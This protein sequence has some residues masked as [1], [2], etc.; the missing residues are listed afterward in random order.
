MSIEGIDISMW[1]G[2]FPWNEAVSQGIGWC[3]AKASEGIG[4]TDPQWQN[5]QRALLAPG[6]IV[7]GS[8]HFL[9]PDLGNDPAG[10]ADWYLSRHDLKCF[11]PATPWIFAL[12]A[13]SNGGSAGGCYAFLDHV[14][15]R[16]GYSCWFYSYSNWIDTRGVQAFNRPLWIAWPN[17]GPAPSHGWPTITAV[18]YGIRST[19]SVGGVD[20]DRFE[21]DQAALLKL[22]GASGGA[23]PV[24]SPPGWDG[25]YPMPD[26]PPAGTTVDVSYSGIIMAGA[27][28]F[29]SPDGADMGA[30]PT[31]VRITIDRAGF[32]GVNWFDRV[33]GPGSPDNWWWLLDSMVDSSDAAHPP[34]VGLT[35][36]M[37]WNEAHKPAPAPA[38]VPPPPTPPPPAPN[39]DEARKQLQIAAD[40]I[41]AAQTAL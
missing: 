2:V 10:E 38:P 26:S 31:G 34:P 22:A 28:W 17:P 21:G 37:A 15:A 16:I 7:G 33:I 14:S 39:V 9:R 1:Q 36:P 41:K 6:P 40:A 29:S 20:A 3:I 4:Y 32:D 13:E 18:Q 35:P 30:A 23:P 27:R 5:N 8:Y 19:F 11:D 12:D 24:T 25:S